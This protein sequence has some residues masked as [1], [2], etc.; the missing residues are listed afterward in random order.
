MKYYKEADNPLQKNKSALVKK[1]F[2]TRGLIIIKK[3]I[4]ILINKIRKIN[5]L[6]FNTIIK[7]ERYLPIRRNIVF[8]C[9][10]DF[11]DNP[12]ALYEYIKNET[13]FLNYHKAIWLVH[14]TDYCKE[15][16]YH[17][18]VVFIN[19]HCSDRKTKL[20]LNYYL[21]TSKWFVFSHP[22]WFVN[23]RK[24]QTVINV[25]HGVSQLKGITQTLNNVFDFSVCTCDYTSKFIAESFNCNTDCIL[26]LGV[27]RLDQL[28][29]KR[30]FIRCLIPEHSNERVI[31]SMQ[32]FKQSFN[33][34]D[35]D[36]VD[37]FSLGVVKSLDDLKILNDYLHLNNCIMIIKI[38]HL[39]DTS[40][41][42][43]EKLSNIYYF[44]DSNLFYAD[45][46]IN[47]LLT[48]ADILIT[49][50]SSVFYD[51]LL[52]DRP[53]GF[54]VSEIDS[55]SRGFV[56]DNPL[57]E[58]PGEKIHSLKELLQFFDQSLNG[59]DNYRNKRELIRNKVYQ[60]CDSNNCRRIYNWII[61]NKSKQSSAITN[62]TGN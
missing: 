50:Y 4:K 19:R 2:D 47:Q 8:E 3:L 27:P 53:I 28:F 44:Q 33:F 37:P 25:S 10:S 5:N 39:Q 58:M 35:S 26:R 29:E 62:H 9:E 32:T 36:N 31:V 7:S 57:A 20:R 59:Y 24:H 22:Y 54:I 6:M 11:A 17:K 13:N 46:Q 21:S 12:R 48:N 30:D 14:K 40:F 34:C 43:L 60:F 45:V 1:C 42:N 38:H 23:W 61:S 18:N 16:F 49:D 55:Y 15:H 51:F 56:Y 41:L 52:L